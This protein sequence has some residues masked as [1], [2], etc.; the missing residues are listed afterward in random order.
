MF[1]AIKGAIEQYP[2]L[3]VAI[4]F[5]LCGMGF[6]L[7][8]EL[9]LIFS[10]YLCHEYPEK[11]HVPWMILWCG[12]AILCGD[13]IP[14]VLGRVFGTRLLRIRWLRVL[15]TRQRLAKFDRWFRRRGDLVIFVARFLAGIRMVAFFTA[16]T[17]KMRWLRF[18]TLDGMGIVVIVPILVYAGWSGGEVINKIVEWVR[19]VE[20]GILWTSLAAAAV[21]AGWYWLFRRRRLQARPAPPTEAFVEPTVTPPPDEAA[22]VPPAIAPAAEAEPAP[23]ATAPPTDAA[24]ASPAPVDEGPGGDA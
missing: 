16:G 10:G 14:F 13:L 17:M 15:V 20:R 11:A 21:I 6:P 8:E 1:D 24:P 7:P 23:P 3:G 22:P 2:Y 4:L 19:R 18:L 12:V 5:V 9:V